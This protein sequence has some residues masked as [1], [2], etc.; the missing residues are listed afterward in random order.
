MSG[1]M[2]DAMKLEEHGFSYD[3]GKM[4]RTEYKGYN[5]YNRR[6]DLNSLRK[7]PSNLNI[8]DHDDDGVDSKKLFR[9]FTPLKN[10]RNY[11]NDP[12]PEG[13]KRKKHRRSR[14]KTSHTRKT[15]KHNKR[16]TKR[17]RKTKTKR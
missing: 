15:K 17:R 12:L 1:S 16:K 9:P 13:G 2:T 8:D 4:V 3:D 6:P 11:K 14:K 7:A 10:Y 5:G